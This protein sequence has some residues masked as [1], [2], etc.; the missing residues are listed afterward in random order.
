MRSYRSK[1]QRRTLHSSCP[2]TCARPVS[3]RRVRRFP[4]GYR[5]EDTGPP[6][7]YLLPSDEMRQ[8]AIAVGAGHAGSIGPTLLYVPTRGN[9]QDRTLVTAV[10]ANGQTARLSD[11]ET[12]PVRRNHR[13]LG[14]L[15][16][17]LSDTIRVTPTLRPS[18]S[19]PGV[20]PPGRFFRS[21][22][23]ET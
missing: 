8:D 20:F 7:H 19:P 14:T 17:L 2:G 9:F 3:P 16:G 23:R 18:G 6:A 10:G 12:R 1:A 11:I 5:T 22:V 15:V 13:M 4:G 21:G